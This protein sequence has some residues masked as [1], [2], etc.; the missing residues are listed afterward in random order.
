MSPFGYLIQL[1]VAVPLFLLLLPTT[2]LAAQ[3]QPPTT[4]TPTLDPREID[5]VGGQPASPGEWP[6]QA[7]VRPGGYLCGGTLVAANW[8][9]TAAH[10]VY[11]DAGNLFSPSAVTVKLGEYDRTVSETSEQ[12]YTVSQVIA[13]EQYDEWTNNNDIALLQLTAP[14]QLNDSVKTIGLL[15]TEMESALAAPGY[16]AVVTGWGTTVE[17][18]SAATRLME[19]SVPIVS[20]TQCNRAYGTITENMICAGY[21]DG[22][23][24][25]CQGDSG[26]PLVVPDQSG[27]WRLAGVV[28]F[29]YGCARAGFY[30]VYTR[31]SRY[32]NWITDHIGT[33]VATATPVVTKTPLP[34]P[35]LTSTP[36]STT[37]PAKTPTPTATP[38]PVP[39]TDP[40]PFSVTLV[41]D[42][43][44]SLSYENPSG[45]S[46]FVTVPAGA[47]S[48][49]MTLIFDVPSAVVAQTTHM[50]LAKRVMQLS[51]YRDTLALTNFQFSAPLEITLTYGDNDIKGIAEDALTL[52]IYDFATDSWKTD[53]IT[54]LDH[55][56]DE[57]YLVVETTRTGIYALV[58]PNRLTFLPLV[59]R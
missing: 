44:V 12:I 4:P 40:S 6:W 16:D 56:L 25:S 52:A 13:H 37:T 21:E 32:N 31:V 7:M 23:K 49:E 24:D 55:N 19:V 59:Q 42:E 35:S 36:V 27:G 53:D 50:Q 9:V 14:A 41:P 2:P 45:N 29:G 38:S 58:A 26:G 43:E 8:V 39:T 51:I 54:L 10:C 46:I 3:D 57:N 5:I 18:G 15:A 34:T 17:G 48:E 28:S 30:G 20:N 22:G 1:F 33:A 11:D 47:V